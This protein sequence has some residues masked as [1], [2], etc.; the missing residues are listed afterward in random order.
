MVFGQLA[1]QGVDVT[2]ALRKERSL[3]ERHRYDVG[4]HFIEQQHP[5]G[6]ELLTDVARVAG[7]NKLGQMAK[8]KLEIGGRLVIVDA[9]RRKPMASHFE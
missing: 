4:F 3:E 7:R 9:V 5:L 6:E 2:T 8:A 1:D